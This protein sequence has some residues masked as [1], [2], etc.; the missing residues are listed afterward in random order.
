MEIH[1]KHKHPARKVRAGL[2]HHLMLFAAL[3]L[4]VLVFSAVMRA[5]ATNHD[6]TPSIARTN[7]THDRLS[8]II[9]LGPAMPAIRHVGDDLSGPKASA[10]RRVSGNEDVRLT[11]QKV[12]EVGDQAPGLGAGVT[13]DTIGSEFQGPLE[14][15]PTI[16]EAGNVGFTVTLAGF[17]ACNPSGFPPQALYRTIDGEVELVLDECD[18]APGT[19]GNFNG[20]PLFISKTPFIHEGKLVFLATTDNAIPP[21]T[22]PVGIW[23]DRFGETELVLY[24]DDTPADDVLPGLPADHQIFQF[25]FGAFKSNI[26]A[27]IRY[28][29]SSPVPNE[30][31]GIWRNRDGLWELLII[32]GMQAPGLPKGVV[33]G[34][35]PLEAFGPI[36]SW[37]FNRSTELMAYVWLNGPGINFTNDETIYLETAG[38]LELLV[39]EGEAAPGFGQGMT[40]G[41]N[42][43]FPV[44]GAT[45]DNIF[46]TRNDSGS[47]LFGSFVDGPLG[48]H[49]SIW[50]NRNGSLELIVKGAVDDIIGFG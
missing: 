43:A 22:P 36:F 47:A 41:P 19:N 5:S 21:H 44:F 45:G 42:V 16:D 1:M 3:P 32:D 23:S 30:N 13:I 7:V 38:G 48:L 35:D 15:M 50:T 34:I 33:F 20:F 28:N 8:P 17:A 2:S 18:S 25:G 27:N 40:F 24:D 14:A 26:L 9:E 37:T 11:V 12:L 39:R 4:S 46:P 6:E 49:N 10:G 29:I 31:E